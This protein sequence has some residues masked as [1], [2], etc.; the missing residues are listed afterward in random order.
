MSGR[1]VIDLFSTLDGVVQAPGGPEED[2]SDGF[3]WGGWQAPLFDEAV[4]EQ[5]T[6]GVREMDA[7][8][9]GR[10]TYDIF[11]AYWPRQDDAELIAGTFNRIPKYVA[12]R[13]RP[14]LD[15]AD[16]TLLGADL[17]AEVAGL[18]ERHANVHVVGSAELARTLVARGLFD[19]LNL[20]VHPIVLGR[21]KRLFPDDGPALGLRLLEPPTTGGTAVLL[22]YGPGEEVRTGDMTVT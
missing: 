11:A 8:L 6:A 22:R 16:S 2:P 12:S 18:R 7:L 15:W 1:I 20:W 9:L 4:G 17:D 5:V 21:G 13:G 19:V 14:R 10:R 3:A